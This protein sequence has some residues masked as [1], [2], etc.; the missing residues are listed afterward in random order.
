M[1]D[2]RQLRKIMEAANSVTADANKEYN[3]LQDYKG[4]YYQGWMDALGVFADIFEFEYIT[5]GSG[6][7]INI[8]KC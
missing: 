4:E 1:L 8:K 6:L 7:I 3:P 5:D 2:Q